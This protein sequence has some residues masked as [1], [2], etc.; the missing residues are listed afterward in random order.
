MTEKM[1]QITRRALLKDMKMRVLR[2]LGRQCSM[3]KLSVSM[4]DILLNEQQLLTCSAPFDRG[5]LDRH[6]SFQ[7]HV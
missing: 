7:Q 5:A 4:M 2:E 1:R 3:C 6:D